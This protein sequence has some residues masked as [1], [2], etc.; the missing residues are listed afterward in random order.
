L[1]EIG[2]Q[3]QIDKYS[4]VS[5]AI[6]RMKKQIAI[7]IKLCKRMNILADMAKKSQEQT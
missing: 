5:S 7:D 3:F 2:R 4:T 1:K 6:E